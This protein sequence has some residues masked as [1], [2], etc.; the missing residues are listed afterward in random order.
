VAA[1][2]SVRR[3]GLRCRRPRGGSAGKGA[4]RWTHEE[5]DH[6]VDGEGAGTIVVQQGVEGLQL[7]GSGRSVSARQPRAKR[8]RGR[9]EWGG[10]AAGG[11]GSH[12]LKV[13]LL[14]FAHHEPSML[15]R[16]GGGGGG[17]RER[18][19]PEGGQHPHVSLSVLWQ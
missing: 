5:I 9:A 15:G 18:G 2:R 6:L 8:R 14:H 4:R 19:E 16:G 17:G 10:G 7:Q 3:K 11:S 12:L 1:A 13:E